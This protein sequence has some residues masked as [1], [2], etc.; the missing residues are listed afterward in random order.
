M[1]TGGDDETKDVS[2]PVAAGHGRASAGTSVSRYMVLEEVGRGAFGRVLC[3]YDPK[4][5]REGKWP[6]RA[7]RHSTL[8]HV[9]PA[10]FERRYYDRNAAVAA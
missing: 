7:R 2:A 9:A 1:R 10:V 5:R 6:S 4:L 3:A 8:G